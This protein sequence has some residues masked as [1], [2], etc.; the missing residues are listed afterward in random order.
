MTQP[1]GPLPALL[2]PVLVLAAL[3]YASWLLL[4]IVS[5][6][7]SPVT[8]YVSEGGIPGAPGRGAYLTGDLIAGCAL[9]IGALLPGW[10]A[11]RSGPRA[12]TIGRIALGVWG[13]G[14]LVDAAFPMTC[15]ATSDPT[16]AVGGAAS[17]ADL[18]HAGAS[19]TANLALLVTV[20]AL[21]IAVTSLSRGLAMVVVV[22]WV[23]S[24]VTT[25]IFEL[26]QANYA[27]GLWQRGLLALTT[28]WLL[29]LAFEIRIER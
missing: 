26:T 14:T 17:T 20:I 21:T 3:V 1:A 18:I 2:R 11:V 10:P 5:G 28:A 25:L 29:A 6:E 27:L 15:S 12:V 9:L 22:M 8:S 19:T 16:C 4:L 24:S 7:P 23:G 13:L